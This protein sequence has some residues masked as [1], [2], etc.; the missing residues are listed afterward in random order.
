MAMLNR[1]RGCSPQIFLGNRADDY[2]LQDHALPT[3]NVTDHMAEYL[4][5]E[6]TPIWLDSEM[7]VS[8]SRTRSK[9]LQRKERSQ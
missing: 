2:Q 9:D 7:E 6:T 4:M 3:S 5:F 8:K 1:A